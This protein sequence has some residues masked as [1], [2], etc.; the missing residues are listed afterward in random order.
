MEMWMP[1]ENA[2]NSSKNCTLTEAVRKL[3]NFN[4]S[5]K[6]TVLKLNVV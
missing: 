3:S 2:K 4:S 6:K 1:S 5:S